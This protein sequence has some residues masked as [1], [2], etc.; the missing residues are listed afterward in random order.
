MG[1]R[2]GLVRRQLR[3]PCSTT[4]GE[5]GLDSVTADLDDWLDRRGMSIRNNRR[6]GRGSWR[7]CRPGV[8]DTAGGSGS[9]VLQRQTRNGPFT[10][11][12][13]AAKKDR[14]AAFPSCN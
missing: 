2:M 8:K 4:R 13:P 6:G 9:L 5:L 1:T 10:C 7:A 14:S 11:S 3:W 12:H